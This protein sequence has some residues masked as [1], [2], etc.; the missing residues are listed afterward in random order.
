[1]PQS[2]QSISEALAQ[3]KSRYFGVVYEHGQ[4]AANDE[5]SFFG[6]KLRP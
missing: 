6:R 5:L 3:P 2:F 1:M 4:F